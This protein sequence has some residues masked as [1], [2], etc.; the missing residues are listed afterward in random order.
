MP[1]EDTT[2]IYN[3]FKPNNFN[4]IILIML[5]FITYLNCFAKNLDQ[6]FKKSINPN[7]SLNMSEKKKKDHKEHKDHKNEKFYKN[8]KKVEDLDIKLEAKIENDS[9]EVDIGIEEEDR[10][11]VANLLTKLLANEY[12]L[13]IKTQK[14]HWNLYGTNFDSLHKFFDKQYQKLQKYIDLIAE[15]I[16]AIGFSAIGTLQEFID[17][18]QLKENP[19]I[20]PNALGMIHDLLKDH[21]SVIRL[22]R[23]IIDQSAD[24]N[25]QGTSNFIADL[26]TK[27]EKHAWMLRAF[28]NE[29]KSKLDF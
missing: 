29:N 3:F 23:L 15:R 14:Y 5:L 28:L 18:K 22:M 8:E 6:Y 4:K 10:Q 17:N 13:A 19:D 12:T 27:H 20:I 26:I 25:D 7:W 1:K 16:R 2:N 24:L 11:A 21:E 9:T